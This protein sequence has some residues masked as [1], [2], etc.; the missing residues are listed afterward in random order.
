MAA[1]VARV[2]H[3]DPEVRVTVRHSN[4]ENLALTWEEMKR[5]GD[6]NRTRMTSLEG[7]CCLVVKAVE[8]GGSMFH[9]GRG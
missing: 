8:Q 1:A 9:D 7:V 2:W 6:G 5:A 4:I 3:A